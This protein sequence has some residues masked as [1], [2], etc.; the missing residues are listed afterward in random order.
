MPSDEYRARIDA[1]REAQTCSICGKHLDYS[2]GY[3]SV[4]HAHWVCQKRED[5]HFDAL[6]GRSH[7]DDMEQQPD[8]GELQPATI[9]GN[10]HRTHLLP[11]GSMTAI[12]GAK[13]GVSKARRMRKRSGWYIFANRTAPSRPMCASCDALELGWITEH[14]IADTQEAQRPS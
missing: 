9:K 8:L 10:P 14:A 1:H 3:H 12:C 4:S 7:C 2:Q 6:I 13:P 11:E 5:D